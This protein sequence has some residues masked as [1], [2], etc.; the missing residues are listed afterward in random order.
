MRRIFS[1]VFG[2]HEPAFTVGSLAISATLRPPTSAMPVTTPSAPRPSASQLASSASSANDSGSTSRATRSRTGHLALLGQSLAVALGPAGQRALE[3][4]V[5]V[6][7]GAGLSHRVRGVYE[8][9]C[10]SGQWR[11]SWSIGIGRVAGVI[12]EAAPRLAARGARPSTSF[13]ASAAARSAPRG[14][15]SNM[16]SPTECVVSRPTKSSSVNGPIGWLAPPFIA[17]SICSIEPDALLARADRVEQVRDQQAVDDEARLVARVRPWSCRA[18]RRT[19]SRARAASVAGRDRP[20]HLEQRHHLG[21]IEEVK[22]EEA[23]RALGR[24]RLVDHARA[25]RCWWRTA[26][27]P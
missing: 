11:R 27:P 1:T 4:A 18:S 13:A 25:R 16:I 15:S 2:P 23:L 6:A 26:P 21:R 9:A 24:G 8:S 22:A 19:R 14:S 3:R 5:E 7:S 17:A 12:V 10:A 20:H